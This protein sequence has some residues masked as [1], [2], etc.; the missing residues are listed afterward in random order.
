TFSDHHAKMYLEVIPRFEREH[1]VRVEIQRADFQSFE[2]RLQSAIVANTD[3]PDLAELPE[4]TLGFF[5]RGPEADFGFMDLTER[6]K[7][8]GLDHAVVEARYPSWT[9]RGR[10]Y[11]L[12]HDV[13][14]TMLAYRKDLIAELG[15][16][17]D[18]LTTWDEFVRVGR[19]VTK[20]LDGD[21]IPD[22]YMLDL[23]QNGQWGLLVML[24][25]RGIELFDAAGQTAFNL[26]GA[27]DTI[28]WYLHQTRG[29]GRIAYEAGWGQPFYKAVSDGLVLF[30]ITPDWKSGQYE[31]SMQSM[32]GK[33]ALMPMPAWEKGGRRTSTYGMTGLAISKTTKK[34][35]LAWQLATFL[36]YDEADLGL[37]FRETNIIPPLKSAWNLPELNQPNAYFSNQAIGAEYARLAPDV[38]PVYPSPIYKSA[39]TKMDEVLTRSARYFD[40]HGDDGLRQAVQSEL[41]RA[42]AYLQQWLRRDEVLA[43]QAAQP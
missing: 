15:I 38:P 26:P 2:A 11:A 39:M 33:M 41:D 23:P 42:E 8:A 12:P 28:V 36:Y 34:P 1:G 6:V 19:E 4:A 13:H 16:D 18:A 25:Q 3:V 31:M 40:A 9:T 24:R 20:D 30:I 37:R 14:P 43:T 35:E 10:I 22:R 32:A 17:V 29:P 27:V 21:G 5:T 7:R